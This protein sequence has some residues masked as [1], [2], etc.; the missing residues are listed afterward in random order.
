[1]PPCRSWRERT[2]A[3]MWYYSPTKN[4]LIY[5]VRANTFDFWLS[6][7]Y[8]K[9][10]SNIFFIPPLGPFSLKMMH[11]PRILCFDLLSL[12]Y[13]DLTYEIWRV[14]VY[15]FIAFIYLSRDILFLVVYLPWRSQEMEIGK[16][17][18]F[19]NMMELNFPRY[20]PKR[21]FSKLTVCLI[22]KM[23]MP[24]SQCYPWNLF[25]SVLG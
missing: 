8:G 18:N 24:F 2:K 25:W 7:Q 6:G 17:R 3:L 10:N 14:L 19:F 11:C 5:Q 13:T 21:F 22:S 1:M 23:A 9:Y 4:K 16:P 20:Q 15:I 12:Q